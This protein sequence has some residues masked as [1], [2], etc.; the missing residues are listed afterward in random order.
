M[1]AL[2]PKNLTVADYWYAVE[3]YYENYYGW[4]TTCRDFT[5]ATTEPDAEKYNCPTCDGFTVYG[6]ELAMMKGW[7]DCLI[8]R[9]PTPI[10]RRQLN[11]E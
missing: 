6:A 8:N 4:C 3:N 5:R 10:R 2:N 7:L 9:K 11:G 1:S